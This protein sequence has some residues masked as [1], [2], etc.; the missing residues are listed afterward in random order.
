MF[1][2]VMHALPR[3]QDSPAPSPAL[4]EL[5]LAAF[6]PEGL[7]QV[8]PDLLLLLRAYEAELA[9]GNMRD[10]GEIERAV[11]AFARPPNGV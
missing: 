11:T 3:R 5:R 4:T 2:A 9:E 10:A 1:S 8:V 6:A 7:G